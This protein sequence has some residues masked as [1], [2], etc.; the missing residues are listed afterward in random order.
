MLLRSLSTSKLGSQPWVFVTFFATLFRL[1]RSNLVKPIA[2]ISWTGVLQTGVDKLLDS[3]VGALELDGSGP[4][5]TKG[6]SES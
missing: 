5:H 3:Q 1:L 2:D 4:Y 6:L